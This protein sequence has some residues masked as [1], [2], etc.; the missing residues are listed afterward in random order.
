ME[1]I[2]DHGCGLPFMGHLRRWSWL[3]SRFPSYPKGSNG[4][5]SEAT[6]MPEARSSRN[7]TEENAV[8]EPE[9]PAEADPTP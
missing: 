3:R 1:G 2:L 5:G 4:D 6:E 7:R 9:S 8:R